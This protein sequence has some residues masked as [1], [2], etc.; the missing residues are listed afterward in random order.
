VHVARL[1]GVPRTVTK[2]ADEIL[3]EIE[4]EA[5]LQPGSGRRSQRRSS[6]YTQLIFFDGNDDGNT[7]A[8][9]E[10]E[11]KDPILEEIMAL[12]LDMM[13]PREA[14]DRLAQYQRMQRERE[15]R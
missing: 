3:R 9:A 15:E 12:D 8:E 7:A 11:K 1:A 5:L 2:R 4:K 6:R 13:T 14:L 10:S